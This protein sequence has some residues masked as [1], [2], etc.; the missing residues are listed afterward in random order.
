MIF[1]TPCEAWFTLDVWPVISISGATSI[2]KLPFANAS[3]EI[4]K[5]SLCGVR[6]AEI[7]GRFSNA[8]VK[9]GMEHLPERLAYE[10][11]STRLT[12][13]FGFYL[14]NQQTGYFGSTTAGD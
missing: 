13:P 12:H 14:I 2:R 9:V 5:C 7:P 4:M 1:A 11:W 3:S 10:K 8:A 6:T